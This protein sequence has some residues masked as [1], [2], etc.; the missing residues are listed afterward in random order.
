MFFESSMSNDQIV[1]LGCVVAGLFSFLL[2]L[3]AP[4]V[5]KLGRRSELLHSQDVSN[6]AEKAGS[7]EK[8]SDGALQASKPGRSQQAA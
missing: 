8:D 5:R 1:L 3:V 2:I 7:V 4:A 6:A